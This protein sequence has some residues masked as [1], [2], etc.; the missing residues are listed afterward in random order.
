MA[1]RPES[2]NSGS[3]GW[4]LCQGGSHTPPEGAQSFPGTAAHLQGSRLLLV[5]NE[6]WAE[7]GCKPRE[8]IKA[9]T[10]PSKNRQQRFKAST[11]TSTRGWSDLCSCSP[12]RLSEE[13][14]GSPRLGGFN[15][16]AGAALPQAQT[17]KVI[18]WL[19]HECPECSIITGKQQW[20]VITR[21]FIQKDM[22]C[23]SACA[24]AKNPLLFT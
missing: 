10:S 7:L 16:G 9:P 12:A 2:T 22:N 5:L 24:A 11:H 1:L 4:L 21:M 8:E 19:F 18:L 13:Q 17:L 6:P 23:R 20:P 15:W 14:K 3:A